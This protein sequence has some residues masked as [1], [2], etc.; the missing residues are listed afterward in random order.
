MFMEISQ[1]SVYHGANI[2]ARLPVIRHT[3]RTNGFERSAPPVDRSALAELLDCLPGLRD[4]RHSCS[5]PGVFGLA[6]EDQG[7]SLEHCFEHLCIELQNLA[8][9][10]LRCVRTKEWPGSEAQEAVYPYEDDEVGVEA[11]RLA[12]DFLS[13]L[14]PTDLRSSGAPEAV[15]FRQRCEEFLRFAESRTL[16]VLDRALIRAARGRDIPVTRIAGRLMQL[17]HGRFQQR[18]SGTKTTRTNV[19]SN[20]LAANKDYARRVLRELGLPVPRY[21]RV[22]RP[23]D[24]VAAAGRIGYPVVVKPNNGNMGHGVSIGMRNRQEVRAGFERARKFGRSVLIEE[25]VPGD[26]Y[27]FVVIDGRLIAAAKRVPG[28]VVG[29]GVQTIEQLVQEVNSDPRRGAGQQYSW[30]CLEFDEQAERLLAELGYDRQSIPAE[31]EVV[32]LRRNANTSDGGT[33]VDVTDVVH[34]DNRVIAERTAKAIGLDVAGVDLI[35]SDVSR[36]IWEGGGAVNEINSRPGLRKH[37]W[38]AEGKPRDVLGPILDMLFP[39]GTPSRADI[40]AVTGTGE[41][42]ETARILAHLLAVDG[43]QVG[44]ATR[45]GVFIDGRAT[46]TGPIPGPAAARTILLD[47]TVD[48]AVLETTPEN[49][50]LHGLSCD[51]CEVCAVLGASGSHSSDRSANAIRVVTEVARGAVVLPGDDP[52]CRP[53]LGGAADAHRYYLTANADDAGARES[54][55]SGR[56]NVILERAAQGNSVALYDQGELQGRIQMPS[57]VVAGQG[58]LFAIALAWSLGT[59]PEVIQR[60]ASSISPSFCTA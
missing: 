60:G 40:V 41:T 15:D 30:T 37:L 55:L 57:G 53:L 24:A 21:E 1:P 44:L 36:S 10:E 18:I 25:F 54:L 22:Y 48:T 12:A 43:R 27:R 3:L 13:A 28:H 4:H 51:A 35:L 8:G 2:Y 34:P 23:R 29:D 20:D 7:F 5:A 26:D 17:G 42:T 38:P 31:N 45:E 50:L 39:P 52:Q 33:A 59:K 11:A 49:V 14:F 6:T 9:A 58:W 46:T 19:V 32:Y 47:P 16:P 56:P